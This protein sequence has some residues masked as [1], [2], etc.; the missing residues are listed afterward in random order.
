MKSHPKK[1]KITLHFLKKND[2]FHFLRIFT[3]KEWNLT[4]LEWKLVLFFKGNCIFTF[5]EWNFTARNLE[6]IYDLKRP[7]SSLC[8]CELHFLLNNEHYHYRSQLSISTTG[9]LT[10]SVYK[11]VFY[12]TNEVTT[13]VSPAERAALAKIEQFEVAI[14]RKV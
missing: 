13:S 4:F 10:S 8:F 14:V 2:N 3:S 6:E 1:V 7:L 9:T 5:W 11:R 12:E